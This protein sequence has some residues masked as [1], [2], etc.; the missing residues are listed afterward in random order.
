MISSTV[1]RESAPRSSTNDASGVTSSSLT[2]N[3]STTTFLT[4][5]Y[6]ADT[7]RTSSGSCGRRS[8]SQ[9][10]SIHNQHLSGDVRNLRQAKEQDHRGDVLRSTQAPQGNLP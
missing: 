2:S 10:P 4:R 6:V 9:H 8:L 5:S 3:C 7:L 1:S